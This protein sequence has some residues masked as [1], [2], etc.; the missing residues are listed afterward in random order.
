MGALESG[1]FA[2][3]E[4]FPHRAVGGVGA[5]QVRAGPGAEVGVVPFR[6]MDPPPAQILPEVDV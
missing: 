4:V 5:A 2:D 1:I 3:R 6:L